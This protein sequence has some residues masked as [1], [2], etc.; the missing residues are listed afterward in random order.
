MFPSPYDNSP[1]G[2]AA[3]EE[4]KSPSHHYFTNNRL[5]HNQ[6]QPSLY[7]LNEMFHGEIEFKPPGIYSGRKFTWDPLIFDRH[8]EATFDVGKL[9]NP[10]HIH[11]SESVSFIRIT[12]SC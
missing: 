7:S 8:F 5:Y 1:A 4:W 11:P 2:P 9:S 10:M 3:E 6:R 12:V